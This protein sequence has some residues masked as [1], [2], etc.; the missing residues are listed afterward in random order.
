MV[1]YTWIY[2]FG[3]GNHSTYGGLMVSLMVK[4]CGL[5]VVKLMMSTL[6]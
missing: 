6:D 1:D 4:I 3:N 5:M 2:M